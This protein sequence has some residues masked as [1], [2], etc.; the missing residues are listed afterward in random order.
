MRTIT[1]SVTVYTFDELEPTAQERAV[2]QVQEREAVR[3][4]DCAD[5]E[6]IESTMVYALAGRL[7]APGWDIYGELDFP[8]IDRVKVHEWNLDRSQLLALSGWLDRDNAPGL[9][10]VDG[11]ES[12]QLTAIRRSGTEIDVV[13][14]EPD[15]TCS[16]DTWRHEPDCAPVGSSIASAHMSALRDAVTD[17]IHAAWVAGRDELE[18]R[19]SP[20]YARDRAQNDGFEFTVDGELYP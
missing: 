18:Y 3:E 13:T 16:A 6:M 15:C 11:I 7:K 4:W 9:P 1:T 19:S 2:Q 20:E 5:L 8:G 14:S 10:W 17:A 12:V